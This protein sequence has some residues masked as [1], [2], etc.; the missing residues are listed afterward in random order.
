M[1]R[2]RYSRIQLRSGF[3]MNNSTSITNDDFLASISYLAC[4]L[5]NETDIPEHTMEYVCSLIG[6]LGFKEKADKVLNSNIQKL[7]QS[8][9]IALIPEDQLSDELS[10][11]DVNLPFKY[12]I[13]KLINRN[14]NIGST[15]PEIQLNFLRCLHANPESVFSNLIEQIF[16]LEE[17]KDKLTAKAR[18]AL[19]STKRVQFLIDKVGLSKDEAIFVLISFRMRIIGELSRLARDLDIYPENLIPTLLGVSA[20]DY[21]KLCRPDQKLSAYGFLDEDNC[22]SGDL[23]D[24]ILDNSMDPYFSDFL[25]PIN[26]EEAYDKTSYSVPVATTNIIENLLKQQDST[27]ILLYGKPGSGKTEYA[28]T[29][30]KLS[31]YRTYIYK[32]ENDIEAGMR[33]VSRLNC[34]L[35]IKQ[36]DT[37]VIV[38]EADKLLQTVSFSFFGPTPTPTKGTV[39]KMLEDNQNKIIW[40]INH[41]SQIDESTRR[42]FTMSYKFDE[43]PL[44]MLRSITKSKLAPLNLSE[45]VENSIMGLLDKYSVTGASVNNIVKTID[46][47]K[48]QDDETLLKSV[49]TVLEENAKLLDGRTSRMRE[50]VSQ[51]YNPDVINTSL[52]PDKIVTMVQNA[53]KFSEKNKGCENGIR[54]LFYGVSGTGKTELVR[55]ISEKL[56]KKIIL[57]R[58]S[59]IISKF[60]GESEQQ[61]KAAFEQAAEEDKILLFDEADS[62]FGDREN[63]S[64]S[65]ERTMTNEFLTQLEEFP[66]ICICTTN[67]KQIM[68]PAMER[69]FQIMVEFKPMKKEGIKTLLS[70]Y[71]TDYEFNDKDITALENTHSVTPGDFGS[72]SSRI[73][74]MDSN[75]ITSDYIIE[76]LKNLQKDKKFSDGR[77]G[78]IGFAAS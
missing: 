17:G 71:F 59:D 55:Y 54:M 62:F 20:N 5:K 40:I 18:K 44:S 12:N 22:L 74:F 70:S 38:D 48:D 43:M 34:Y 15:M 46:V 36:K 9:K 28:K 53:I 67:L 42:R 52:S 78:V 39:N 13:D 61:I 37:V 50:T 27:S 72:L 57:K 56:N 33:A 32:N 21:R 45:E 35:S 26:C 4:M 29:L 19:N 66:G 6:K 30:G 16:L 64:Y 49:K 25:K 24:C 3:Q 14:C 77:D 47:L 41:T 68:D 31:G 10:F 58:A 76:E 2:R 75:S 7:I 60:V 23:I 11:D 65:W 8:K 73:R 51:S 63:A 1:G 69:R